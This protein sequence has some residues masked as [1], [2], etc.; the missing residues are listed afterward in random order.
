MGLAIFIVPNCKKANDLQTSLNDQKIKTEQ[1]INSGKTG[2]GNSIS[3][4]G[5]LAVIGA[6]WE[7]TLQANKAGAVYVYEYNGSQW[8]EKQRIT[9]PNGSYDRIFGHSVTT[10]GQ[11][12]VIT[13]PWNESAY[14]YS[15]V[16][17]EWVLEKKITVSNV[18]SEIFGISCDIYDNT[19]VI[20]SGAVFAMYCSSIGSAYVYEKTGTEWTNT[21]ILTSSNG[22]AQD[23]F[24]VSVSIDKSTIA[25]GA[26]KSDCN[27]GTKGYVCVF[28]KNGTSWLET[29]KLLAPDGADYNRFGERVDIE[30]EKLIVS[31]V[32]AGGAYYFEKGSSWVFKQKITSPNFSGND[33][34][35]IQVSLSNNYLLIGAGSDSELYTNQ[36]A[37]YL[38]KFEG[39][40]WNKKLKIIP[41]YAKV[42]GGFGYILFLNN[43]FAFAAGGGASLTN[44]TDVYAFTLQ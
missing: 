42:N 36:G 20:G 10:N 13:E 11:Y 16:G 6:G 7:N 2:Y 19:I 43:N 15:K 28:E 9:N 44:V 21:A 22:L 18:S 27:E 30:N 24:G 38:F 12:I 31:S 37:A 29:Q 25:I 3:V 33:G 4:S 32:I 40:S 35:G 23:G 26:H 41:S 39:T 14:I 8:I 34:F 17:S 1:I 5:N